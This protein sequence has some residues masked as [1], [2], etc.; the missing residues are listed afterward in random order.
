MANPIGTIQCCGIIIAWEMYME[1]PGW[2]IVQVWRRVVE[3]NKYMLLGQNA[4]RHK[5]MY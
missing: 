2:V 5:C 3:E 4:V 1:G